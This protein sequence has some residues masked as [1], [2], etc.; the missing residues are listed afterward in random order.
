MYK[1]DFP[2][3]KNNPLIYLD[4]AA[5][6]QKPV[7]VLQTMDNFYRNFYANV[8]RGQCDIAVQATEAYEAARQTVAQFI[9]A[10]SS[11]IVF[12]KSATE[13]INLVANSY[14]WTLKAGDE[15]LISIAE[16]H[17]NFV[18][19]QQACLKS[20][21][22]LKTA[23]V[24]PDGTLDMTDF[25]MKLSPRTKVVA[26]THISNVLGTT[27]P[28]EQAIQAAHRVGAR[29]LIDASQSVAHLPIDVSVLKCDFL[30]FSGHKIYGPTGI[31]VLY[32]QADALKELQPY[33][34]GGDMIKEVF[35]DKTTFAEPPACFEAGT[36]PIAEALGLAAA[37]EY[38][39]HIGFKKIQEHDQVLSSCALSGLENFPN[40][41]ILGKSHSKTG[42]VS[43]N[44]KG[45]HP[46]DLAFILAKENICVRVGH[47]CAMP[48]HQ[49]LGAPLSLRISFGIYNTK[50]DVQVFLEA[51]QKAVSF[52]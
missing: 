20:G 29:I 24:L 7:C 35:V 47:H 25:N 9:G 34:Y 52:F 1:D 23:G 8:H 37:L 12:T 6:A 42:L 43:F 15:V 44:I 26:L 28:I 13:A 46:S 5:S 51:L 18:P 27:N 2:L 41:D 17:A 45:I 10:T 30:A 49:A 4:T 38:I 39:H 33:Q 36:P 16:H 11:D 32:G 21:A 14:A 22:T 40:G 48:L 50:T 19:W 3:L 31:G